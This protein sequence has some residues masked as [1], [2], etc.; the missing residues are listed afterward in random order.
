S[1][2][3]DCVLPKYIALRLTV[4][5]IQPSRVTWLPVMFSDEGVPIVMCDDPS[6]LKAL[7]TSPGRYA[8]LPIHVP[9][10]PPT[11]SLV[12]PSPG[13]QLIIFAGGGTHAGAV[14][15]GV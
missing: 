12:F 14:A 15:G 5:L 6:K 3:P 9:V 2:L 1:L 10:L 8:G 13:H 7:S 4:G 11:I